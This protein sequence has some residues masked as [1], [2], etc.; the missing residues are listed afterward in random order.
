MADDV[1]VC[2]RCSD[3]FIVNSK[4]LKCY[5]CQE[6]YHYACSGI[7]DTHCKFITE[8]KNVVWFCS[9]CNIEGLQTNKV[10]GAFT[11]TQMS[12]EITVL[13]KEIECLN[14]EKDLL[15][16]LLSEMENTTTLLKS[17]VQDYQEKT[18]SNGISNCSSTQ[19]TTKTASY[20]SVL[21]SNINKES[22]VLLIKTNSKTQTNEDFFKD[23][24]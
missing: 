1:R 10:G 12:C 18:A 5:I 7:R 9:E 11:V 6:Q 24:T 20:S 15:R 16:K 2:S 23:V 8:C 4:F 13:K 3:N 19:I 14:R 22:A 21:T 17:K